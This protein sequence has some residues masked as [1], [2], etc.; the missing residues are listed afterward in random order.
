MPRRRELH[1]GIPKATMLWN[2]SSLRH[3]LPSLLLSAMP[4]CGS[5]R[6]CLPEAAISTAL[7][8]H[9]LLWS[10]LLLFASFFIPL[11]PC[12]M[13]HFSIGD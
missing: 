10:F 6:C 9:S 13:K 8:L 1:Y 12:S 11:S 7:F 2:S 4:Q 5:P 3:R